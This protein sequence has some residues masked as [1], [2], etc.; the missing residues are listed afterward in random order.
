MCA[1]SSN[2]KSI[3]TCTKPKTSHAESLV[4]LGANGIRAEARA[5]V[6]AWLALKEGHDVALKP[7]GSASRRH[8]ASK[9]SAELE[10]LASGRAA[11]RFI[12]EHDGSR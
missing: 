12:W 7:A 3:E 1:T 9:A 10:L 5:L 6:L 8:T 4:G 11:L 2:D